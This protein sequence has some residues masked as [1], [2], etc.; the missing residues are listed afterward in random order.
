MLAIPSVL[1][2]R[3]G[4]CYHNIVCQANSRRIRRTAIRASLFFIENRAIWSLHCYHD[5]MRNVFLPCVLSDD[6]ANEALD[7]ETWALLCVLDAYVLSHLS[8]FDLVDNI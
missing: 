3:L 5:L 8:S 2:N 1:A 4:R 7:D 6:S